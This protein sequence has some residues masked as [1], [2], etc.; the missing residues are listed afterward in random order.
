[1]AGGRPAIRYKNAKIVII[2]NSGTGKSSLNLALTEGKPVIAGHVPEKP[3]VRLLAREEKQYSSGQREICETFLCDMEW[4]SGYRLIH[5]VCLRHVA[6]AL[7]VL[8]VRN[9]SDPEAGVE[10]WV[11]AVQRIK[12]QDATTIKMFLVI[13]RKDR[14]GGGSRFSARIQRLQ[15]RLSLNAVFET[16][17]TEGWGISELKQAILAAIAW[18]DLPAVNSE[19]LM[20]QFQH[21]LSEK[22]REGRDFLPVHELQEVFEKLCMATGCRD[23][24]RQAQFEACIRCS[25]MQGTIRQL[26]LGRYILLQPRLFNIY[27]SG[28]IDKAKDDPDGF[29]CIDEQKAL[30]GAFSLPDE[31]ARIKDGALE[32][33]LLGS[34]LH[35][36]QRCNLVFKDGAGPKTNLVF[37]SQS[38]QDMPDLPTSAQEYY[39]IHFEG[40]ANSIYATLVAHL[41][42]SGSFV[43]RDLW[44]NA[45]TY[46]DERGNIC[47]VSRHMHSR[48]ECTL[49]IFFEAPVDEETRKFFTES[50]FGFVKLYDRHASKMP[51][52]RCPG[53]GT[54]FPDYQLQ[55]MRNRGKSNFACPVCETI[56][57]LPASLSM[58]LALQEKI[59]RRKEMGD[60]DVFLCCSEEEED[61]QAAGKIY[62]ELEKR[63][64]VVWFEGRDVRPGSIV[65]REIEK[66][67]KK[68]KAAVVCFG[69][70]NSDSRW[71]EVQQDALLGQ[72]IKRRNCTINPVLLKHAP[73]AKPT[74]ALFNFS[75]VDFHRDN[76]DP[77]EQLIWGI[78][79]ENI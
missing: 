16:S 41:A 9:D 8:D 33:L 17:A 54:N 4:Y 45:V 51:A 60:Y 66:Q 26:S 3:Q 19:D 5:Q 73:A 61:W 24:E 44:R 37:P 7:I 13:T 22:Q 77:I 46:V 74:S 21:F 25:E 18:E 48:T 36:F 35:D 1:M 78:F 30:N 28:L 52:F 72:F 67:I 47:G 23:A 69:K 79:G 63:G 38:T 43:K 6:V 65:V 11:S 71:L 2:G 14:D 68:V 59:K 20:Q 34:I 12:S 49:T 40:E 62:Q 70:D 32:R 15:R 76:P 31:T 39:T 53:C 27:A 10:E 57:P 50:V 55:S 56:A 29:G 75:C 58:D 64:V 42:H